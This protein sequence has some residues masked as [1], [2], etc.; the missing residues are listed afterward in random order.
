MTGPNRPFP[1]TVT[2][3]E[4]S[5][6]RVAQDTDGSCSVHPETIIFVSILGTKISNFLSQCSIAITFLLFVRYKSSVFVVL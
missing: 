2:Q 6:L 5:A 1:C 3:L 4:Y